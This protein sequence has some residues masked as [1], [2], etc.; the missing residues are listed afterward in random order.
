[1]KRKIRFGKRDG[2]AEGFVWI[3]FSDLLTTL[4]MVFMV[5]ALWAISKKDDLTKKAEEQKIAG[6]L[7]IADLKAANIDQLKKNEALHSIGQK[8]TAEFQELQ[9]SGIC[10]DAK[11]E[12]INDSGGF[13][14][15]QGPGLKPWFDEGKSVLSLDAQRCLKGIGELWVQQIN[16]DEF[17]SKS[18]KH[19]LIEGHANTNPFP[20]INEEE[21]FLRN[22]GLSQD[23]AYQAA[24]FLIEKIKFRIT[25][26]NKTYMLREMMI[27]QGKSYLE[28]VYSS[29]GVE[30]F[31]R[32]KRLEFK[33]I[34]G[35]KDGT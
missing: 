34:L 2:E 21:N 16:H 11:I 1:M 27:A 3:T 31:D 35:G 19:L 14:I 30:D 7:C 4:F 32:S 12:E 29:Q 25:A 9:K 33:I 28:P 8:I 23:R 13:R 5:I 20:G 15:F 17:I 24:R 6:D 18:I 10:V 26:K 22:L